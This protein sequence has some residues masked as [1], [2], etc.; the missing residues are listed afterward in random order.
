[1]IPKK[2]ITKKFL[3]GS[4]L[5]AILSAAIISGC[6]VDTGLEAGRDSDH[7]TVNQ[8]LSEREGAD[9]GGEHSSATAG[10]KR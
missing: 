8:D 1:M 4:V 7:A 10:R 5:G 6:A 3:V 2:L 9:S